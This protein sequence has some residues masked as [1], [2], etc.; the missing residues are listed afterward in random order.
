MSQEEGLI[1]TQTNTITTPFKKVFSSNVFIPM[2]NNIRDKS[3]NYLVG[4]IRLVET[5]K[6]RTSWVSNPENP[7]E[8]RDNWGLYVYYDASLDNPIKRKNYKRSKRNNQV[9]IY[10]KQN[11]QV[12]QDI[13]QKLY[14]LYR[15]YLTLI[16]KNPQKY[17]FIKIF[18]FQDT[19]IKKK[20]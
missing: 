17:N 4:F 20:T 12:N 11:F 10:I 13:L 6:K 14:E 18:S 15:G 19:R 5:F 16:R 1:I 3:F 8:L 2:E 7:D 9:N